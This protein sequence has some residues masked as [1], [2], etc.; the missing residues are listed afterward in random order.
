VDGVKREWFGKVKEPKEMSKKL[1]EYLKSKIWDN[2]IPEDAINDSDIKLT[3]PKGSRND[4]L[5]HIAGI[6]RKD[7]PNKYI[8]KVISIFNSYLE[9]PLSAQEVRAIARQAS[10]YNNIDT[11]NLTEFIYEVLTDQMTLREL[12]RVI[13]K[14]GIKTSYH[15]LQITVD[16]LVKAGR[17]FR[18]SRGVYRSTKPVKTT[19]VLNIQAK[20]EPIKYEL[21]FKITDIADIYPNS[22]LMIASPAGQ[23][24]THIFAHIVKHLLEQGVPVSYWDME[25]DI[26][27]IVHIFKQFIPEHLLQGDNLRV[28]EEPV[29]IESLLLD[30]DR[31]NFVDPIYVEDG[32]G[33]VD[34]I[35][36]RMKMQ[37]DGG[38]CFI[39][40]H[41]KD[42][43]G[44]VFGGATAM[45][46]PSFAAEFKHKGDR[47]HGEF[48]ILKVRNWKPGCGIKSIKTV[49]SDT[50]GLMLD[51][52]YFNN[53][54]VGVV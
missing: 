42:V 50:E 3:I 22:I 25:N 37:L 49:W 33:E 32:W 19:S 39:A 16:R 5:I 13:E 34:N 38:L 27:N 47:F 28:N 35:M 51:N 52:S 46:V 15:Y 40:T 43:D 1:L 29:V 10:K 9:E 4:T 17:V 41:V 8:Y 54:D 6:L 36:R 44:K 12:L 21:P 20:G 48:K 30:K 2:F 26:D 7:I 14:E 53:K 23:G 31:V 45:K 24:K 11:H 18:V